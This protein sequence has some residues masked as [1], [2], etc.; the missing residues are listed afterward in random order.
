MNIKLDFGNIKFVILNVLAGA[1]LVSGLHTL[2]GLVKPQAQQTSVSQTHPNQALLFE[3]RANMNEA[4]YALVQLKLLAE[5][6]DDVLQLKDKLK[7]ALDGYQSANRSY[8]AANLSEK[9]QKIYGQ[10]TIA[11]TKI[12]KHLIKTIHTNQFAASRAYA[13]NLFSKKYH[14]QFKLHR[15]NFYKAIN[16]LIDFYSV[17]SAP[18]AQGM[19]PVIVKLGVFKKMNSALGLLNYNDITISTE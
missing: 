4:L 9:E 10:L 18:P 6:S 15:Q 1:F 13:Q 14:D 16:T 5:N 3:M 12:E 19:N 2:W 7:R 17:V 8:L 11:H